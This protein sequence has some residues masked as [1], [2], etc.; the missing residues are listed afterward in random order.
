MHCISCKNLLKPDTRFCNKCGTDQS[1]YTVPKEIQPQASGKG[2]SQKWWILT[3]LLVSVMVSTLL[4]GYLGG[5]FGNDNNDTEPVTNGLHAELPLEMLAIEQLSAMTIFER[6]SPA[7]FTIYSSWNRHDFYGHGSGFFIDS[8]GIAVTAYHVIASA[9]YHEARLYNGQRYEILG[10]YNTDMINDLSVIRVQGRNFQTVNLGDS[11]NVHIGE[12]VFVIG[13]TL[14]TYH[15]RLSDG[16]V[17]AHIPLVEFD[18]HA[19]TN[20]IQITA[21]THGGNSGGPVFN[22]RGQVIG[23]LVAGYRDF[24]NMNVATPINL[25]N[26]TGQD[27]QDFSELWEDTDAPENVN[28][29]DIVGIWEWVGGYYQFNADG[30]GSRNWVGAT[31]NFRWSVS[32]NIITVNEDTWIV[33]VV[34]VNSIVIGGSFFSR[35]E[36]IPVQDDIS[37]LMDIVGEWEWGYYTYIFLDDGRGWRNW[38]FS[39]GYFDWSVR[40][41]ILYIF[42]D[43]GMESARLLTI[44]NP[45]HITIGGVDMFRAARVLPTPIAD[46]ELAEVWWESST[47]LLLNIGYGSYYYFVDYIFKVDGSAIVVYLWAYDTNWYRYWEFTWTAEDGRIT[48]TFPANADFLAGVH[49]YEYSILNDVLILTAN[50]FSFAFD[51]VP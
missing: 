15:N 8:T 48:M 30:T 51:R 3:A 11:D 2:S 5:F 40:G 13:T 33:S 18:I 42:S 32:N 35:V 36:T 27:V 1:L 43:D 50:G 7:V 38:S 17:S 12:P 16:I 44:N 6:Y 47:Y 37:I 14:G 19:I 10:L 41:D 20:A 28:P 4:I 24:S 26:V 39:P 49:V 29:A 45:D 23:V 21:S 9:P 34:D 25:L 31:Q 46:S 22:D